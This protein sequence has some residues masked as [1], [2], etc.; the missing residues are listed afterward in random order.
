MSHWYLLR[1]KTGG[2]RIAEQ[3]LSRFV[4]STLLPLGK[5]R[6]RQ[7]D[8][9]FERVAPLFPCYLFAFFSLATS[10]RKIRYT[11]GVREIVQFGDQAAVVPDWVIDHLTL[12]CGDGPVALSRNSLSQGAAVRLVG[13]PFRE[14]NAI[15]DEYL[16]GAERVAVLLSVMNAERRVVMPTAMVVPAH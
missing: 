4:D 6:V 13:G 3:Q 12:R 16:D 11:P 14:F 9:S 15:F 1:T 7:Q 10:A 2:E 8:R 5:M